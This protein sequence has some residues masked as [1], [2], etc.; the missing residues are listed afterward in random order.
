MS[1]NIG[2]MRDWVEVVNPVR[3]SDGALGSKRE[4]MILFATWARIQPAS[5]REIFRYQHLE[6]EISH[7]VTV[8]YN[9]KIAQGQY[10]RKGDRKLYIMSVVNRDERQRFLELACRE[11]GQ[12]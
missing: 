1:R 8:R 6:Q 9:A 2:A 5:G 7:V 3:I 4:D 12:T 11:G 10:I